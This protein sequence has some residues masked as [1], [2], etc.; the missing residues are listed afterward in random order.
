[1]FWKESQ[2]DEKESDVIMHES[3]II[4]HFDGDQRKAQKQQ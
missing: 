4:W 2:D 3:L 1:M